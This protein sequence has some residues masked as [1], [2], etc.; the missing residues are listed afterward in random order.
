M[1][2]AEVHGINDFG[3]I[4]LVVYHWGNKHFGFAEPIDPKKRARI[5]VTE[6]PGHGPKHA[7][8][9]HETNIK[10]KEL[11]GYHNNGATIPVGTILQGT[12]KKQKA[13]LACEY[14]IQE[15]FVFSIP[16]P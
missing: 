9:V 2:K 7:V 10:H 8:Y 6:T 1:T 13:G 14:A 11:L 3:V 16:T 4:Q 5:P 12:L 15:A